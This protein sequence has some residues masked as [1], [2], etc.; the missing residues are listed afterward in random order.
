M[1]PFIRKLW[2]HEARLFLEHMLRLG[3]EARRL[4][5]GSP[6]NDERIRAYVSKAFDLETVLLGYFVEG[7]LRGSAELHPLGQ[8][9]RRD[10]AE[11]AFAI[12]EAWQSKGVGRMLLT[13]IVTL[14]RNRRISRVHLF[15]QQE[16]YRMLHLARQ[17]DASMTYD[18][19]EVDA[20]VHPPL[21][22]AFSWFDEAYDDAE[23]A[24]R[25]ALRV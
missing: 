21:A 11:A 17:F 15:C 19:G 13:R 1:T 5:F 14:A 20:L 16:N 6:V 9:W 3:P 7:T 25:A 24:F 10:A 2:P 4:R 23:G 22:N 12:E 18:F 8:G